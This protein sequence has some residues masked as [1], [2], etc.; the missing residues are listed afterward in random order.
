M[1][2][3][4][5]ANM[6]RHLAPQGRLTCLGLG[7]TLGSQLTELARNQLAAADLVF[8]HSNTHYLAHFLQQINPNLVDLQ[9]FYCPGQSRSISYQA[10]IAAVINAVQAGNNVVW[11]CYGHPGIASWPPH[12]AMRQLKL[13]GYAAK[14]EAGIAAD[15][16]LYADLAI[17]PI[18]QGCQK[19]EASQFLFYQRNLDVSGYVILWQVAIVGDFSLCNLTPN[20]RYIAV[21]IQ[22]LLHWYPPEHLVILYE[23]ADL[24]IWQHRAETLPLSQL[25][26]AK[27]NQITTLVIPPLEKKQINSQILDLLGV[28]ADHALRQQ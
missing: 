21:L 10:M 2:A 23:A 22:H 12:E 19:F 24:P 4:R 9:P 7:I 5:M 17:D 13:L 20:S 28:P 3:K 15:A 27:L 25:A 14:M 26:Q 16:C 1:P 8:F 18:A 6:T 11:A